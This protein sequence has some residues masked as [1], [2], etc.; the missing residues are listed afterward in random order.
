V[1]PA[2]AVGLAAAVLAPVLAGRGFVLVYDMVFVP[3][4]P[5]LP[6]SV[7]LGAALPRAVPADAVVAL[8]SRVLPGD[9]LQKLVLAAALLAG[10]TGA[11]RLVPAGRTVV[12]VI[13]GVGYTW[14]AFVAERLFLGHWP[15][16]L[17]YGAL[18]WIVW[19][20]L[21]VRRGV[22]RAWPRL[23]LAMVPA[24]LGPTGGLLAAGAA[25][26][27]AGRRRAVP[28]LGVALLLNA[29][30]WAPAVLRPAGAL[31][32]PG[33][34][35]AFAARGESWGGP[36][37]SAL[38]L[39]GIW[40][41]EVV[42]ASRESTLAPVLAVLVAAVALYGC[43]RLAR[44]APAGWGVAPARAVLLLGALGLV[45]GVAGA[46][47]PLDGVLRW[48]VQSVPGA[49]LLRDGQRF[50]AW[51]A[52]VVA[53]G[54]AAGVDGLAQRVP[55][56]LGRGAALVGAALLPIAVLP[57]LAWG[58]LGRL[59]PATYPADWAPV[60][61][62][63]R[64]EPADVL[65]LPFMTYRAFEWNSY[66]TQLDPAPRWLPAT[67]VTD[68]ALPVGEELVGGEDPRVAAARRALAAGTPPQLFGVGWV[69]VERGTPG[70]LPAWLAGL[71]PRYDGRWLALYRVDQNGTGA[72]TRDTAAAA[73]GAPAVPVLVA[74]GSAVALVGGAL[75]WLLLPVGR[76][77]APIRK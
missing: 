32:D 44:D 18:P 53:V 26:A 10:A 77:G 38:G 29:P 8:V 41:A 33:A 36:V 28:A 15:V 76:V 64:H 21:A 20:G 2:V 4:Q 58:G 66:R 23:V 47:P 59:Q 12:R 60:A 43:R 6:A 63:V 56:A 49:G 68:D 65:V 31:S 40:N 1:V 70:E 54:G 61:A 51:W 55:D 45:I 75:L 74:D 22:A 50:V 42:P 57:D 67:T 48:A 3:R 69:L 7:G 24:A 39:G 14:N 5:L 34:V 62:I 46:V 27:A 25:V 17:A 16:L 13:A 30:W 19:H 37:L 71:R 35:A 9:V 73:R 11:A 52:L 72:A